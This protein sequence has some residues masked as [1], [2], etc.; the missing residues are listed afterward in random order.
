M[1]KY[2]EKLPKGFVAQ[3][4]FQQKQPSISPIESIKKRK[5]GRPPSS[6]SKSS[7]SQLIESE[8]SSCCLK[9]DDEVHSERILFDRVQKDGTICRIPVIILAGEYEYQHCS[10]I[11][12]K[13][14]PC[15]QR[16]HL[17]SLERNYIRS[18]CHNWSANGTHFG[19]HTGEQVHERIILYVPNVAVKTVCNILTVERK[20][21]LANSG[22]HYRSKPTLAAMDRH[23]DETDP[24]I[25]I[26][27]EVNE[28]GRETIYFSCDLI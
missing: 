17:S 14:A 28:W 4:S 1:L 24:N 5:V 11:D 13:K 9:Y 22:E 6:I 15:F 21:I 7:T 19:F 8:N 2:F 3:P 18:E 23:D 25:L 27:E 20:N 12:D 16:R 10:I 26:P